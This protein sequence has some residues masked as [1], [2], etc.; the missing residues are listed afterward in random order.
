MVCMKFFQ[1]FKDQTISRCFDH[2]NGIMNT[3]NSIGFPT[4]KV[5]VHFKNLEGA[6]PFILIHFPPCV[7]MCF[8]SSSLMCHILNLHPGLSWNQVFILR[9]TFLYQSLELNMHWN[10]GHDN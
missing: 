7:E 3:W 5:G 2:P 8:T 9:K 4:H 6:F 10:E 1:W